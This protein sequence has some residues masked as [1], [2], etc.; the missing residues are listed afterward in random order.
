MVILTLDSSGWEKLK[1]SVPVYMM[2]NVEDGICA[3]PTSGQG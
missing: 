2:V 3:S 1:D